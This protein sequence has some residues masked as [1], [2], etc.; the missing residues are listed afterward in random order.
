MNESAIL[1]KESKG[2]LPLQGAYN[3]FG[4]ILCM[5]KKYNQEADRCTVPNRVWALKFPEREIRD[6]HGS[7]Q[8][9][10]EIDLLLES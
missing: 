9:R 6:N 4:G 10:Y 7:L 8:G 1:G 5:D 3:S 2:V